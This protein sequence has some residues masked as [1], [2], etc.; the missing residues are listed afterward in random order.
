MQL[1]QGFVISPCASFQ[2]YSICLKPQ[3]R[4]LERNLYVCNSVTPIVRCL[5]VCL[6]KDT[7]FCMISQNVLQLSNSNLV[8]NFPIGDWES[9]FILGSWLRFSRTQWSQKFH[10]YQLETWYRHV[11][12]VRHDGFSLRDCHPEFWGQWVQKGPTPLLVPQL[13]NCRSHQA[14]TSYRDSPQAQQKDL[15]ISSVGIRKFL[16]SFSLPIWGNGHITG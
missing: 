15:I 13:Y 3:I 16:C 11:L 4:A 1:L 7:Y 12:Q 8:Y 5:S 10:S 2:L 14:E 6:S 9:L